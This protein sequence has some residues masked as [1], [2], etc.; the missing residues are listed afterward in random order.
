MDSERI[1]KFRRIGS[2][3]HVEVGTPEKVADTMEKWIDEVGVDGFNISYAITPGTF[4]EFWMASFLF[5]KSV[6]S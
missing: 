1:S 4:E 6:A 2:V 3:G 5:Y